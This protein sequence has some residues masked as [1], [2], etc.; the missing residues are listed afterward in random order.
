MFYC[1]TFGGYV[2]LSSFLPLFLRDRFGVSP[3]AA[4]SL[5]AL[6]ALVG[7]L[8]RPLGGYLADRIGGARLLQWLLLGIALTYAAAARLPPLAIM[9]S[10]L[11]F[12]MACLGMGNGAVFQLVP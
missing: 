10:L 2:G 3:V 5:T 11:V 9:E 12:G 7:S 6:A 8:A 4:G 1:V